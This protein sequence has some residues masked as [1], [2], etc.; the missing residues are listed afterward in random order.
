MFSLGSW[1]EEK[2]L[3]LNLTDTMDVPEGFSRLSFTKK[4]KHAHH[5]FQNIA[6]GLGLSVHQDGAGNSWA[7]WEVDPVAPTIALGSHLDTVDA[8]GG[9]DG[10]AGMVTALAA[11]KTLKDSNFMPAKN[12]AIICFISEESAR[13]GV[14]TIGSKAIA[15]KLNKQELETIKDRDGISIKQAMVDYGIDFQ[16][17]D[18]AELPADRLESFVELHIEQG[19]ELETA[20]ASIGIIKGIACPVRLKI[21]AIGMANHTGTTPMDRRSDAFAAIAPLVAFVQSEA[22][23][24]NEQSGQPL[25]ATVSTVI[26]KPNAMNVIPGEVE[27]GIDIRSVDDRLKRAFA[28]KIRKYCGEISGKDGVTIEVTTLV[29]NDSVMLNEDMHEKL[30]LASKAAGHETISMNSGAGHDVMNMADRWPSGLIFIPCKNG[31][32][33]HPSEHASIEDLEKGT[34]VMTAFLRMEAGNN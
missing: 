10:A 19:I 26:L 8:G 24:A 34:N 23:K 31:V 7:I 2:L 32:S 4:E 1:L 33:H 18:Q 27:L 3:A 6:R 12:I 11:I 25:V 28:D 17:I 5:E 21:T 15:G 14:S 16:S 13:F 22:L 30:L 20:G 9:Y 29:D